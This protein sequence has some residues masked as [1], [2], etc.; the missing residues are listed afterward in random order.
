MVSDDFNKQPVHPRVLI[1][2]LDWGLG[3][4]TRCIPIIKELIIQGCTVYI[5]A[6]KGIFFL[7]KKEF[8]TTVF[9]PCKGYEIKFGRTKKSFLPAILFQVPKVMLTIFREHRWLKKIIK[10]FQIDAIISDNRFGMYHSK[11]PSVYITHQLTIKT[12]STF[13]DSIANKIHHFFIRKY[14]SCWVP[15]DQFNCI[16]GE[17]SRPKLLPGNVVYIGILSRF[18]AIPSEKI[19]DLLITISGP[20]PQR[21]IFEKTIVTQLETFSGSALLVRGLPGSQSMLAIRNPQVKM[22]NHL[23]GADLNKSLEQSKMIIARSGYSTI[24]DLVA[25]KKKAILIPTPG[26][27]EQEYLARYHAQ[28]RYFFVAEE[29]NFSIADSLEKAAHY[30]FEEMNIPT[31]RY[32][33]IIRNFVSSLMKEVS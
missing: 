11:I 27:T 24:M 25:L 3:H 28:K 26:Q 17:L 30:E 16:G 5:A 1:A 9:L 29:V 6:D 12:G 8:P 4:A 23:T 22:V 13:M 32:K 18:Q 21:S 20:E 14:S 10:E 33:D 15:D 2:P 7:L 31:D 19:Y